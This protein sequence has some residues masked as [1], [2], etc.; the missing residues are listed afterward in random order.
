MISLASF[1]LCLISDFT[2]SLWSCFMVLLIVNSIAFCVLVPGTSTLAIHLPF[3]H[4]LLAGG[5]LLAFFGFPYSH[6]M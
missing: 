2:S 5:G 1:V 4:E 3:P 6:S